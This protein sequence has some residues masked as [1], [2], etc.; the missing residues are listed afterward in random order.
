MRRT[1]PPSTAEL[2]KG[3]N[4]FQE[5]IVIYWKEIQIRCKDIYAQRKQFFEDRKK[6]ETKH[7]KLMRMTQKLDEDSYI[8]TIPGKFPE[9]YHKTINEL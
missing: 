3:L 9:A 1:E 8:F 2:I 5:K 7:E 4:T 6:F